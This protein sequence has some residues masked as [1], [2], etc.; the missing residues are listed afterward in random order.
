VPDRVE[1]KGFVKGFPASNE[2][3]PT[4]ET[5]GSVMRALIGSFVAALIAIGGLMAAFAQ[6]GV[7]LQYSA[8]SDV[9]RLGIDAP[10][11]RK[12]DMIVARDE[13]VHTTFGE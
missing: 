13:R 6:V 2:T 12:N 9:Q 11:A 10:I 1:P 3:K 5:K 8:M 4:K 7:G